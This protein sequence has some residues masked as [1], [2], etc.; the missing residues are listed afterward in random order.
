MPAGA[1][2]MGGDGGTLWSTVILASATQGSGDQSQDGQDEPTT[3][4][5]GMTQAM[6]HW[7]NIPEGGILSNHP[8]RTPAGV[9]HGGSQ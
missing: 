1:R 6:Q 8:E 4:Q 5:N 9:T 7:L 3:G 2:I